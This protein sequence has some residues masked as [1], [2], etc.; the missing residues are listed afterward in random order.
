MPGVV[1]NQAVLKSLKQPRYP[2]FGMR[3]IS[4]DRFYPQLLVVYKIY[5]NGTEV[6]QEIKSKSS[7]R[8]TFQK[9]FKSK[10]P[11]TTRL[12]GIR[13]KNNFILNLSDTRQS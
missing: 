3:R 7:R 11:G 12:W 10:T 9:A 2:V 5:F 6:G 1:L 8:F 13:D 4:M